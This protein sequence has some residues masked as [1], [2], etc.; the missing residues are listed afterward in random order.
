MKLDVQAIKERWLMSEPPVVR[1]TIRKAQSDVIALTKLIQ[2]LRNV[3]KAEQKRVNTLAAMMQMYS[4]PQSWVERNFVRSRHHEPWYW[5][6]LSLNNVEIYEREG[7]VTNQAIEGVE[8]MQHSGERNRSGL[9][10]QVGIR[11]DYDVEDIFHLGQEIAQEISDGQYDGY[12][13]PSVELSHRILVNLAM[14][15]KFRNWIILYDLDRDVD[16]IY[17]VVW[18]DR[19]LQEGRE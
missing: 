16:E 2:Y 18:I 8:K 12:K 6:N 10:I 15:N 5:A 17:Y 1:T 4:N 19:G 13:T 3:L 7:Q 9:H 11:N 14:K